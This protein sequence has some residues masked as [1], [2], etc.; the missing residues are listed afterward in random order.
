MLELKR[1]LNGL[2]P[3]TPTVVG[4]YP[5]GLQTSTSDFDVVCSAPDLAHFE[6]ALA[7]L[8]RELGMPSPPAR[9]LPLVPEASVTN[10]TCDGLPV[11]V[12]C[13]TIPVCEQHGFRH[14]VIEGRLLSL[15][16]QQLRERVLTLRKAG[17]KTEP[18]FAKALDLVGDPSAA[19]LQLESQT[20]AE[21]TEI[22]I[23]A[24]LAPHV[25][26]DRVPRW[27][28]ENEA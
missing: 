22:L 26:R 8:L 16:G 9:R 23:R 25:V 19:L 20:E 11:E 17:L 1:L 21:L 6:D 10:L 24:A 12:S 15:A 2:A 7:T 27:D 5:L 13:Q 4:T 3:F 28:S 14:M 18:A